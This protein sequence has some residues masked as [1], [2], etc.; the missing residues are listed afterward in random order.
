MDNVMPAR[1]ANRAPLRCANGFMPLHEPEAFC[2]SPFLTARGKIDT[3]ARLLFTAR[4]SSAARVPGRTGA[5]AAPAKQPINGIRFASDF[6]HA[7][8]ETI[9]EVWTAIDFS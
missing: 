3:R 4:Q 8:G 7:L 1:D 6:R 2:A 5:R 9:L